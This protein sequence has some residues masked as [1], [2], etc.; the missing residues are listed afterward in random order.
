[1]DTLKTVGMTAV[2]TVVSVFLGGCE[3]SA[4]S[5]ALIGAGGG[6]LLGQAIGGNTTGTLI[7][8]GVGAAGEGDAVDP[9]VADQRGADSLTASR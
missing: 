7:G 5:G 9:R 6:A 8:A 4:Q 2:L 3:N 1:M